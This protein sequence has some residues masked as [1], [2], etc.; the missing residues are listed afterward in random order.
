LKLPDGR[1]RVVR[2]RSAQSRPALGVEVR[3]AKVRDQADVAAE[4]KIRFI[5]SI[6]PKWARALSALQYVN[7]WADAPCKRRANKAKLTRVLATPVKL[8][9]TLK[10]WWAHQ[11]SNLGP[12][13]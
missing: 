12:F 10:I 13:D 11:G 8:L 5:S 9:G 3:R 7:L 2:H 6:L 1:S 4:E